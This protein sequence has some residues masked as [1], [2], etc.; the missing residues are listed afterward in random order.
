MSAKTHDRMKRNGRG[1]IRSYNLRLYGNPGK[2]KE[3]LV[4]ML[5][6][7]SWLWDYVVRY[8]GKG[9]DSTE[10]TKGRGMIANQAF[11]RARDVLKAGRNGSITTGDWFN[12]PKS[13]PLL[14]D[15]ALEESKD[16]TFIY[17]VKVANGPRL[18]AQTH[19]ALK[20]A[21]RRGGK[22]IKTCEVRQ[23]KQGW[24]YARVFIGF[25][26]PETEDTEDYIGIDVG[27]NHGVACSDGYLGKA[28]RPI[29]D[30]TREK[31]A[32]RQRQ[33]HRLTANK[34]TCKQFLDR[35]AKRVV[36]S[37]V[38]GSKTLILERPKTLAQLKM[39]GKNGQWAR[40]HFAHRV[41][42][43]AEV[44]GVTVYFVHPAYT[45]IT[46]SACGHANK[47]N[48]RGVD[49]CCR[50]CGTRGHADILAARNLVRKAR[51]VFPFAEDK[52]APKNT[53]SLRIV[54]SRG[55]GS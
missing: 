16:S 40:A 36:A 29:L 10:S 13:L 41:S 39:T 49:F 15:G 32:E 42:C 3:T 6:Y 52:K 54:P 23:A 48:R 44:T 1:V 55:E 12:C 33:K 8:Y 7:R 5:E 9:E 30:R 20:N 24:L 51:R 14:C 47:G 37:A 2:I 31:N 35:E 28:L 38:R 26:K 43:L 22:L 18:P 19:R 53:D 34:S 21:L 50:Q 17:W 4:N 25:E 11:K 27:I 45:S 46:C